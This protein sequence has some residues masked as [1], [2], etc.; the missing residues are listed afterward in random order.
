MHCS[1]SHHSTGID[2]EKNEKEVTFEDIVYESEFY[3]YSFD[4]WEILSD[5]FQNSDDQSKNLISGTGTDNSV[6]VSNSTTFNEQ[7]F[8]MKVLCAAFL[9]LQFVFVFLAKE[10]C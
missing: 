1:N 9:F 6:Q 7:L 3:F 10:F 2:D 5:N 4:V 8:C